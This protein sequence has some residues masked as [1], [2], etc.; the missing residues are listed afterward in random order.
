MQDNFINGDAY[1]SVDVLIFQGEERVAFDNTLIGKV[2]IELPEA[3]ERGYYKFA[4][5]FS[6]DQNGL[7]GVE[8]KCLNDNQ[9]WRTELVCRV[10]M[11][12]QQLKVRGDEA[13]RA[14]LPKPP[15][16]PRPVAIPSP[17]EATPA[18]HRRIVQRS[19]KVLGQLGPDEQARLLA[20]YKAYVE[21]VEA[22]AED[23]ED[24]ADALEDAFHAVRRPA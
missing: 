15:A 7:L 16:R 5:T 21:A 2:P 13:E 20:P 23:L 8:V 17:P 11:S 14:M 3:R 18:D 12:E 19:F 24:L 1:T 9:I 6:L 4:V 22:G 10:R